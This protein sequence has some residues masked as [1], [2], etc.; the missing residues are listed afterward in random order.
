MTISVS[1]K[2]R[3]AGSA[4]IVALTAGLATAGMA[5]TM[6]PAPVDAVPMPMAPAA[7]A[8]VTECTLDAMANTV[9]C[10]PG[11]D[12]DGITQALD[13]VV[14]T[15]DADAQVQGEINFGANTQAT[16]D[17][18]IVIAN[19]ALNGIQLGA[20][21]TV[22]NN[23]FVGG[24]A[25][26]NGLILT[27]EGSTITNNGT[28]ASGSNLLAIQA[29]V[30]S[31]VV[32]NG[33][34]ALSGG[35]V[36]GI[37]GQNLIVSGDNVTVTNSVTGSIIV[38]GG[39]G[40][41]GGI[42][43]GNDATVTNDG[44]IQTF[45][46]NSEGIRV[47]D[48]G[49]V[50]NTGNVITS[51]DGAEGIVAGNDS[52]VFNTA[53]GV[54]STSG[55]AAAS[56]LIGANST[57]ENDGVIM[58]S[59]NNAPGVTAGDGSSI[60]NT[61]TGEISTSGLSSTAVLIN[62]DGMV[63]N[64][65]G[66]IEATG[67]NSGGVRITGEGT[68]INSGQIMTVNGNAVQVDG[69]A[70][71]T[72]SNGGSIFSEGGDAIRLSS[73]GS[74]VTNAGVIRTSGDEAIEA[75]D[76]D[77]ITIVNTGTIETIGNADKAIEANANLTITNSGLIRSEASEAIEADGAGLTLTNTGMIIA[78]VDD[79]VDGADNVMITN[80]GIIRGG[81]NDGLELNSGM[82]INSG[83]I[84][85][86]SSDPEGT[87]A[88][89][90][91]PPEL[92]AGIDFDA[93]TEG[94]EDGTVFNLAGGLIIGD[95]GIE[96]SPG[97]VDSPTPSFGS[98]VVINAGTITG[99]MGDAV[100]LGEGTDQFTKLNGGVENGRV[101][102]GNGDDDFA[103]GITDA[104]SR[105]F[106][107]SLI[108]T[109]YLNFETF[110]FGTFNVNPFTGAPIAA[111]GVLTLTGATGEEITIV[112]TGIL[113]GDVTGTV[114]LTSDQDEA[115][116]V[117]LSFT[118][119]ENGSII[120]DGDDA[121]EVDADG[122]VITNEGTIRSVGS[123][124]IDG[125]DVN[126]TEIVNN[127]VIE[128]LADEEDEGSDAIDVSGSDGVTITNTGMIIAQATDTKAIDGGDNL[129]V[130]NSGIIRSDNGEGKGIEGDDNLT[131]TNLAGGLI[132][133]L[134][135]GAEAVE[136][137]GPGLVLVNN[138]T[139][140][141]E[142][143][144]AVDGGD[145][146]TITNTGL[147]EGNDND[148][149]E[150]NSGTIT[151]SGTIISL[152]SDPEG[153][154]VFE[155]GPPELDAG[156]DFDAG[157]PGNEDGMVTNLAGGL[158]EGD[159]GIETSP[160]NI[161][162]PTPNMGSQTV[163]NFG[164]IT[165]RMGD[166]VRLGEGNDEF[167]QWTGGV[168][169]GNILLGAGDDLFILEG[170]SA[171]VSA[172]INGGMGSD[173][174]ILAG[175]L[176]SDNLTGFEIIQLGSTLGGSLND[177]DIS[178]NRSVTG[179]VIHTGIVNVD[180]G[181]D[182]LTTTGSITLQASG[183]LNILTPLDQALLGQTVLV[184]QDGTGFTNEGA[185]IN[186][187]D[188]D[189][190]L[191]YTPVIGSLSVRVDAVQPLT[192]NP[193]ANLAAIGAA[194]NGGLVAG[195][196]SD[197]NFDALNAL[198]STE[199]FANALNDALPSLSGGV[200]R[201]IFETGSL[202]SDALSRHLR[203]EGSG[204]WGQVA[205]RGAEQ[206]V[207]S[208]TAD[209]YDSNQLVFAVG[210]DVALGETLRI[211]VMASY[212]DIDV[213]DTTTGTSATAAQ[214]TSYRVGGYVAASLFGRGFFNAEAS[215]LTGD[216]ETA[217]TGFFGVIVS[218][219]DLDGVAGRATLGYDLVADENV[220]LTPSVGVNAARISFDDTVESGGFNFAIEREDAE[221]LEL[222]FGGELGAQISPGVKGFIQGNVIHDLVD[223]ARA[224][225]LTSSQLT[226]FTVFEPQP[227]QDRFELAAGA[228]INV[229]E[230]FKIEVGYLGDFAEG[231]SGHSAR[232]AVRI[233]F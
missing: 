72:N 78:L 16:I 231:Y 103:V 76:L 62:G 70:T 169:N 9:A 108:G 201:E 143:D 150:L 198:T 99:R 7:P 93:G 210:G 208:Q 27:G 233:G 116:P 43:L 115:N 107:L 33:L 18:S 154:P 75:S 104:T 110:T 120:V 195:T 194:L 149:L 89:E 28:I 121:L 185:T 183:V 24:N 60:V 128:S 174:A 204:I 227:E 91:G 188:N 14:V 220:W 213:D 193:D 126:D 182:S 77:N 146:V 159:I 102:G 82:I 29:G 13:N 11:T 47:F 153:T 95:I 207:R 181:V 94:N 4:S 40:L 1:T 109:Q 20:G 85:S 97:N 98:H 74:M 137:D 177:L 162:N 228:T 64:N 199:A 84:E 229:S 44:L 54:I 17:G 8:E 191:T 3:V 171:S 86:V 206:D 41:S 36:F 179:D 175:N 123:R 212:A 80:S 65:G 148:G 200:G 112:N 118:V 166:A 106:D 100:R 21:S 19:T 225:R 133:A 192:N 184:L 203:S 214:V 190:L 30:G 71:I 180:L 187:V 139:I 92:D 176:N 125:R 32:N 83:T 12:A 113:D 230:T 45:G 129:T 202:A 152:G 31:T 73:D 209:G 42:R 23:G 147:I 66:L 196:L 59:G 178:G 46:A 48:R 151:N 39:G 53:T 81:E 55:N 56:I 211:G 134:G 51:G 67:D 155:G 63:T 222:R 170:T 157:T 215:Y 216:V 34:I 197:A 87:P 69:L 141:S 38:Q 224:L 26:F 131:V 218:A 88:V 79:A 96:T 15:V 119:T 68:V 168:V 50:T 167:Q 101:D 6:A 161:D 226:G 22:V 130:I 132:E 111:T 52:M 5:Q 122:F 49:L 37:V 189:L 205:V 221:F 186:I 117:P 144:D 138:G 140:R 223:E 172:A 136:A 160:G 2:L 58:T 173:T 124:A 35:N 127:G 57:F 232:A 164:T 145:D 105:S 10:A 90:G 219:Y 135:E 61:M 114:T 217:R 142:F 156:I 25:N 165:G 163:V 158:I